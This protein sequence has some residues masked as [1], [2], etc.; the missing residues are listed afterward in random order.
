M[1]RMWIVAAVLA[2]AGLSQATTCVRLSPCQRIRPQ[3]VFFIGTVAGLEDL[4]KPAFGFGGERLVRVRMSVREIFAGLPDGTTEVT[5]EAGAW[6]EKD[7][8]YLVDAF[9]A[10]NGTLSVGICGVTG[11]VDETGEF[12]KYLRARKHGS[13]P[14]SLTVNVNVRS[15]MTN[16]WVPDAEVLIRGPNGVRQT[17]TDRD[18]KAVFRG[19]VAGTYGIEASKTL[20]HEDLGLL[21]EKKVE[22]LDQTC[23]SAG[24]YL[25]PESSLNGVLRAPSGKAA[26]NIQVELVGIDPERVDRGYSPASYQVHTGDDGEFEFV[27]VF[28]GRYLLGTNILFDRIATSTAP[29]SWYPGRLTRAEAAEVLVGSGARV[30]G[31]QFTLPDVGARR[32]IQIRVVDEAGRPVKDARIHENNFNADGAEFGTL[33]EDL[34]TGDQGLLTVE[35]FTRASYRVSASSGL[36][37]EDWKSSDSADIVPGKAPVTILLVVRRSSDRRRVLGKR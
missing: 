9:R 3:S 33:G 19:I 7:R 34:K 17:Q 37:T 15:A 4:D 5:I 6:M 25:Q 28:P 22:V 14:T 27:G 2:G 13:A 21:Q 10:S 32:T 23:P 36:G 16:L 24:I 8:D 26:A 35:G 20:F 18:G 29:R 31:V 11:S 30:D 12:L 1:L